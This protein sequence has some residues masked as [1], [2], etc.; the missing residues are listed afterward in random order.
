MEAATLRRGLVLFSFL[1]TVCTAQDPIQIPFSDSTYGFDGPWNAVSLTIGDPSQDI[2]LIPGGIWYTAVLA[3]DFCNNVTFST[4][5]VDCYA[6]SSGLY[7]NS[8]SDTAV[9]SGLPVGYPSWTGG[10]PPMNG[11]SYNN[12]DQMGFGNDHSIANVSLLFVDWAYE[13]FPDGRQLPTPA[14]SLSLGAPAVNQILPNSDIAGSLP[15]NQFFADGVTPSASVGLHL[16]SASSLIEGGIPGSLWFGGLSS[17]VY[18]TQYSKAY[19]KQQATI[20][21]ALSVL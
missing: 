14:G 9:A 15:P 12:Y 7:D 6:R 13:I 18:I 19:V 10:S 8:T 5:G 2:D 17:P 16:G 21:P 4:L 1:S 20:P 3:S 11:E